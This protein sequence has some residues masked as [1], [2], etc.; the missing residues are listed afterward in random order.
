MG[1]P[2]NAAMSIKTILVAASGGSATEGAIELACRLASRLNAHVEAYHVLV[3][4][5]A[6][7]A[8][9]GAGEGLAVSGAFI[10]EMAADADAAAVKMKG[11]FTAAAGRH[12]LRASEQPPISE[13]AGASCAWRQE[14]GYAPSLVAERARF[15]DLVVLGRS[16]RVVR[17]PHS[18]TIEQVL[19][20]AGRPVL[21]APKRAPQDIGRSVALAWNGSLQSVRALAAALPLLAAADRVTL[22]AAGDE[23]GAADVIGYLAWHR[24][25]AKHRNV[26]LKSGDNIGTALLDAAVGAGAD[27][28]VMGGYGRQPWRETLFGGATHEVVATDAP[29]PLLLVH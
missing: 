8:A 28:L 4:P 6:V 2:E 24:I 1:N 27:L 15:F 17:A 9:V 21:V 25:A 7:F 19:E 26:P 5:V 12:H 18:D 20:S 10:D 11:V 14:T 23:S 29:L 16:E 3:D 22:I 13:N